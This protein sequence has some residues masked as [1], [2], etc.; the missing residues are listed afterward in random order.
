V[1]ARTYIY[2]FYAYD[3]CS[4]PWVFT[5]R[6]IVLFFF[7]LSVGLLISGFTRVRTHVNVHTARS[8]TLVHPPAPGR[9]AYAIVLAADFFALRVR[10]SFFPRTLYANTNA[11]IFIIRE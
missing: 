1:N 11:V 2:I 3:V 8:V 7:L 6:R 5:Y 10:F 4:S 9:L